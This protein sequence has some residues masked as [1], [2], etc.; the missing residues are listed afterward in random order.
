[1]VSSTA[2]KYAAAL[3]EVAAEQNLTER[4]LRELQE[5]SQTLAGSDELRD[6]LASPALP[7]TVKQNVLRQLA[8]R[9]RYCTSVVNFLLLL[10]E[11]SRLARLGEILDAVERE[12]DVRT[13]VVRAEVASA[14]PLAPPVRTR[15]ESA[16]GGLTGRKVKT[17]Y[18]LDQQLIG[19]LKVQI[20]SV[21]YDGT[22]KTQL[23]QLQRELAQ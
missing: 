7:L 14:H 2:D 3:V 9:G 22:L 8:V 19:G 18:Q 12:V 1:M 21:V 17:T 4:I 20:G 15:L 16:L 11:R 5:F 6:F 10:Q 13:G 23:D